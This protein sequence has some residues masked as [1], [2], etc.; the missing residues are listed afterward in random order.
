[1]KTLINKPFQKEIWPNLSQNN[2]RELSQNILIYISDSLWKE[3]SG[4]I[5]MK[6]KQTLA[7]KL[8][9]ELKGE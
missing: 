4:Q 2:V 6:F 1:M 8:E 5:R 7:Q 9:K 3:L